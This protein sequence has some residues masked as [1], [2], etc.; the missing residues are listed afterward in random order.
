M[1]PIS[2]LTYFNWTRFAQPACERTIYQLIKKHKFR[3][4]V[5][6]GMGDGVCCERM[7]RV[8]QKHG[9]GSKVRYTGVD[10]FESR[11][12][13]VKL[14]LIKMHRR[15]NELGAKAQLVPGTFEDGIQRIAN[16]HLRTDLV[17]V[18]A[19]FTDEALEAGWFY[20]PRMLH[21][22]SLVLVQKEAGE[23]YDAFTRLDIEKRNESE[24]PATAAVA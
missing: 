6:F 5:E 9:N 20:L 23:A 22:A 1:K 2:F 8:A 4:L 21:P 7:I 3:S 18:N 24:I 15:L 10:L 13:E 19:G 17:V 16:S 14:P 12:A 11:D